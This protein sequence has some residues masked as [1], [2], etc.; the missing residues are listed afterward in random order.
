MKI[1][2]Y[3][4]KQIIDQQH[5][6]GSWGYFHTLSEPKHNKYTTEQ[7]LRRLEI[8]GFTLEDA[9]VK[10]ALDYMNRCL[11]G[12]REIPDRKE[13]HPFWEIYVELM[14]ATW[15]CRFTEDSLSANRV[16]DTWVEIFNAAY[17]K[18][19]FNE[20]EYVQAFIKAFGLKPTR[21]LVIDT[22]KFYYVSILANALNETAEKA[23]F[24]DLLQRE[25]GIYY[26]NHHQLNQVPD[27]FESKEANRFLSAI[28]ELARYDRCVHCLGYVKQWLL[29]HRQP[30]GTWD[31]GISVKDHIHFPLS[32][33]W[34]TPKLRR[35]DI[36]Y[37][38]EKLIGLLPGESSEE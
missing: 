34:R 1:D 2:G 31:M 30:D 16:R 26:I 33:S 6:D 12:A 36:T 32:D 22:S 9:P 15:I 11:E 38:I 27:R 7:A 29:E 23:Y 8:L 17:G 19:R 35:T 13:K 5:P 28:E 10:A 24:E 18:G 25:T 4:A 20:D 3:W 21:N 37:R 14:L